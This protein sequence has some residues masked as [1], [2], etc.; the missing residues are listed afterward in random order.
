LDDPLHGAADHDDFAFGEPRRLGD[1]A[2]AP[3]MGGEGAPLDLAT[4]VE[5]LYETLFK[6][7]GTGEQ[8]FLDYQGNILP[9]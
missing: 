7:Q 3:D 2:N 6:W 5:G 9:W 1:G 8:L 4:S